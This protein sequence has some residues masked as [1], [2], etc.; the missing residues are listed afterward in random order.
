MNYS[1]GFLCGV[2]L[3]MAVGFF[4]IDGLGARIFELREQTSALQ[5]MVDEFVI[6]PPEPSPEQIE[7]YCGVAT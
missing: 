2:G 1:I 4:I 5:E 7:T 3:T 6:N